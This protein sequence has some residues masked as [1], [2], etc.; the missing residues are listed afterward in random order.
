[1]KKKATILITLLISLISVTAQDYAVTPLT[2]FLESYKEKHVVLSKEIE[3]NAK[4]SFAEKLAI[5]DSKIS[6]IKE[7]FKSSRKS[8]YLLKSVKRAKR[9][10]CK[11]TR[12]RGI[13]DCKAVYIN[14]PNSNM[15]TKKDW[16]NIETDDPDKDK[17]IKVVIDSSSVSLNITA[18]GTRE[19]KAAVFAVFKYKPSVISAIVEKETSDLFGQIVDK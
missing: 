17:D 3:S 2:D 4:A 10:S 5:Y 15:Y 16:V 8:E 7:S 9:H 13:T 12:I 1:M 6:K 14:A 19:N 11:G 18:T